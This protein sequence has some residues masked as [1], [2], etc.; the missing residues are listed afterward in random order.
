MAEGFSTLRDF[1]L[2][3]VSGLGE[4]ELIL[5]ETALL[6]GSG[7]AGGRVP[8]ALEGTALT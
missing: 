6:L 5:K 8:L 4:T 3:A 1:R 2:V 7:V